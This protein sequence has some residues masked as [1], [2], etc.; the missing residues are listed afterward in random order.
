MDRIL[1]TAIDLTRACSAH[2]Q[3]LDWLSL[4]EPVLHGS[5][6]IAHYFGLAAEAYENAAAAPRRDFD[7][8]EARELLAD[9]LMA[10]PPLTPEQL[11]AAAANAIAAR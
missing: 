2:E 1:L 6:G 8:I 7:E 11:T 9:E 4:Y 10:S 5:L 3:Y